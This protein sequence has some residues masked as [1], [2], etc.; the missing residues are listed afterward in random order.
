MLSALATVV[1]GLSENLPDIGVSRAGW[2]ERGDFVPQISPNQKSRLGF[3]ALI[4]LIS[5][6]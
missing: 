3:I 6:L 1:F 5:S 2:E 4:F